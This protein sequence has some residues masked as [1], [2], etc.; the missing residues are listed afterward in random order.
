[1]IVVVVCVWLFVYVNTLSDLRKWLNNNLHCNSQDSAFISGWSSSQSEEHV[2]HRWNT[3]QKN[4]TTTA[5]TA[6]ATS[7][8][9]THTN[10]QIQIE[11]AL[12][13]EKIAQTDAHAVPRHATT[14]ARRGRAKVQ[15]SF[16]IGNGV[17]A[18]EESA[19]N[20]CKPRTRGRR[21]TILSDEIHTK[22]IV[23]ANGISSFH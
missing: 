15:S 12:H 11:R 3:T 16:G 5:R 21:N 2:S 13:L 8:S 18:N 4:I 22:S 14:A 19:G 17:G 10:M 1:M 23:F 6:E 7:L 20:T 9:A